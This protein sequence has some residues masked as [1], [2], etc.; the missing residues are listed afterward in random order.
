MLLVVYL[1]FAN[2]IMALFTEECFRKNDRIMQQETLDFPRYGIDV[3]KPIS[4]SML[5]KI[6]FEAWAFCET[7][8]PNPN[9]QIGIILHNKD[10]TYSFYANPTN[11]RRDLL[12]IDAKIKGVMHGGIFNPSTILVKDG[13]Y[14]VGVYCYENEYDYGYV[15]TE[16]ILTKKGKETT[17]AKWCSKEV[18]PGINANVVADAKTHVDINIIDNNG[19]ASI[20]GWGFVPGQNPTTLNTYIMLTYGDGT[21]HIFDTAVMNRPDLSVGFDNE[22]YANAGF[23]A[24]IPPEMLH[25]KEYSV[26]ILLE[27]K[28]GL[29]TTS[30]MLPTVQSGIDALK[31]ASDSKNA[32]SNGIMD[33]IAIPLVALMNF[34]YKL[35][36]NYG[37]AII[38]FTFLTKIILFPVS[39]WVQ[40]NGI[41]M[42]KITPELNRIKINNFGDKDAIDDA[43]QA[44]YKREKYNPLASTVP[45]IL[46]IVMLICVIAAVKALLSG[47][48]SILTLVPS[49][50]GGFT[51]LM[52][53]LAGGSA[54]LLGLAQNRLNPLQ[55]EQGPKE[56]WISNGFSIALSLFLG[57]FVSLGVGIYWIASNLF[58][59]IQQIIL[60]AI[61]K[62][63]KHIDYEALEDSKKKLAEM[64]SLSA[65]ISAE[66]KKREQDDYKKFFSVTN[67]HLVMYSEKSGFYKYYK[68]IM[69]FMLKYSNVIIH[70][71]T[72]DP[73]D[74]IFTIAESQPRIRPYY[75]SEKK[76]ITMFMKMD[77]DI[78][79]MT[80][81]DLNKYHLKRSYVRKDIEY[82]YMFHYPLSTHMVL[83]TGALDHY[84]TIL[85]VGDFQF[86]EIRAA[87]KLYNLPEKNLVSAGYGQL[88]QLYESYQNMDKI[89]RD[90]AKIL[91]APSWQKDNILDS[92]I[93]SLLDQLLGKGFNIVIRPHPEYV[94]RYKPRMDTIVQRYSDKEDLVFELDFTSNNS[95]FDSDIIISDWSG[96]AYEFSLVT[97]KPSVF[98][99][100]PPK[101]NN[102]D[103][104][105]LNIEPLEF[106]LRSEVGIQVD[107]ADLT[108]LDE[109]INELLNNTEKY[110]DMIE[111]IRNKYI[112][113]F[114]H[115]GEV[116]GKYILDKLLYRQ[117]KN[118]GEE[119]DNA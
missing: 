47:A 80:C 43:T 10:N 68:D 101:I 46:Q 59:I 53:L 76:L 72:N 94:K 118:N 28:N 95:L 48:D 79:I 103:Y 97:L 55:K 20:K 39:L 64:N 23:N 83:N 29:H 86:E 21:A 74:Q 38:V 82:V 41:V 27:D 60:N 44:L 107:P 30:D 32:D 113:N 19:A 54:L 63:E 12:V 25:N 70:Y 7:E 58:S 105:K 62:P 112:A 117:K 24:L 33:T 89:S 115:S 65:E 35:F 71:V 96:S 56:Q 111:K 17:I 6:S 106:K 92:C 37:L 104:E 75:I 8:Y 116:G 16:Y 93:D 61:I 84:D 1:M 34:L 42:V 49:R 91:I 36:G 14:R 110:A 85:C 13:T 114:G 3:L 88:E 51:Y 78:V 4:S 45:M 102:P 26:S 50:V 90:K 18:A 109:I 99:N 15:E 69:D 22:M 31:A 98:I 57:I 52:P 119:I 9:K 67:K 100:T 73:K 5:E 11:S 66:D 77:A 40:K 2:H 108:G 87:E 81:P